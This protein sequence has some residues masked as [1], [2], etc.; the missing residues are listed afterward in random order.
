MNENQTTAERVQKL[1]DDAAEDRRN[2]EKLAWRKLKTLA[3]W[4]A[5]FSILVALGYDTLLRLT[6]RR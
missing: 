2:L 3:G 6:G 5:A 1:R 4:I